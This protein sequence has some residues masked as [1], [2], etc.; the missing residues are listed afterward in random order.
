MQNKVCDNEY[1]IFWFFLILSGRGRAALYPSRSL[2][3]RHLKE[4]LH[5]RAIVAEWQ[6]EGTI[7]PAGLKKQVM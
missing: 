3:S 6:D 2:K 1:Q 7:S 5:D 4:D